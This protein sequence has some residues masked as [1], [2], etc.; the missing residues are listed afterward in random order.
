MAA[1]VRLRHHPATV[2]L[3]AA[4]LVALL[5]ALMAFD[6]QAPRLTN[7]GWMAIRTVSS[8]QTP[9]TQDG[10]GR[11]AGTSTD[12]EVRGAVAICDDDVQAANLVAGV[13]SACQ[14]AATR[15]ATEVAG[16]D[17][18]VSALAG[19]YRWFADRLAPGACH[20]AFVNAASA[21]EAA[22]V[23]GTSFV[24]DVRAGAGAAALRGAERRFG[25]ASGEL[26]GS[27]DSNVGSCAP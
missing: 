3:P 18:D 9:T 15:C 6:G 12:V 20:T 24:A 23:A 14:A 22:R 5:V 8:T 4:V 25:A 26:D 27:L 11:L 2:A 1:I 16:Y 17:G 19:W 10:C 13:A 7:A 21:A